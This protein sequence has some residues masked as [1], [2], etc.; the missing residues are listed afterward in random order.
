MGIT[1][2]YCPVF[3][4]TE[5][6]GAHTRG[7]PVLGGRRRGRRVVRVELRGVRLG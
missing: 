4:V 7:A 3:L 2:N 1:G 5:E 6:S